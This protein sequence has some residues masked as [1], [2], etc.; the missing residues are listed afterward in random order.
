MDYS[1]VRQRL[2]ASVSLKA[3]SNKLSIECQ[4]KDPKQSLHYPNQSD[5]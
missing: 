1:M 2:P 3:L 4:K 5:A